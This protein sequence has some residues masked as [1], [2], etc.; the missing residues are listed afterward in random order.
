MPRP[1][2]F[3]TTSFRLALGYTVLFVISVLVIMGTTYLAATAEMRSIARSSI[4]TDLAALRTAFE[5]G[6][7]IA[8][9]NRLAEQKDDSTGDRFLLIIGQRDGVSG[10]LPASLWHAGW[11]DRKLGPDIVSQSP[12]LLRDADRNA[13]GEVLLLSYGETIGSFRV[14]AA[15][16][17]HVIDEMQEIM[18]SA[19]LWGCLATALLALLVG[20]I[21]ST[22][23]TR[24]VEEIAA[25][26]RRIIAGR[27]DLRL[28]VSGRR[29]EIDRLAGD[30][31]AMLA[32]IETLMDSLKQVSTDIAHDLR[33]P[34]SRL[35]QRLYAVRG[36]T[37]VEDY[38]IA[39]DTAVEEA[40]AIIET[41]NALL[42]IA[43][44][45]AGAR[46]ARFATVDVS[47]L[48]DKLADIYGEV[49]ADAGHKLVVDVAHGLTAWGDSE[50]LAQ[51]LAN[52][53][54]N[55][56]RHVPAPG[57]IELVAALDDGRAVIE[58]R[59]DGPG[60]PEDEREK[61]F[62]RLYRVERSR[63][64]SGSGLGLAL[65]AAIAELH[66]ARI[67]ALDNGPGLRMRIVMPVLRSAV[68]TA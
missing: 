5:A 26:T 6:G 8:L 22:G 57:R 28:P 7:V 38:E 12:D 35:R 29:D 33:T 42:R 62:R 31:N 40:D 3:R 43:Q 10:N 60:V 67:E 21:V 41:F 61:I 30:I 48:V 37:G 49:A 51:M 18:W 34:L 32:R 16:N 66:E 50:L 20:Y 27:L 47:Q 45:E 44:I 54:E 55:A 39:V 11:A 15:R 24:R 58:I 64:T 53:V 65:V 23:P 9:Q 2:P 59:D 63:T 46:K 56:I 17:A 4:T 1:E 13:D 68:P 36:Q 14:M 52:L 19:L 25:T